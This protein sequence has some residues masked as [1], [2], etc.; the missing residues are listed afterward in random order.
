MGRNVGAIDR[1]IARIEHLD[2]ARRSCPDGPD[3]LSAPC[4][5]MRRL[6]LKRRD[7]CRRRGRSNNPRASTPPFRDGLSMK[8][9][10]VLSRAVRWAA[11]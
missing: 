1:D 3:W 7:R 11:A 4:R 9:S 8:V 6:T 2:H 10:S 5:T